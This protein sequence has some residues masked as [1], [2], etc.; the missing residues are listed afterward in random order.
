MNS[1]NALVK[2]KSTGHFRLDG[3]LCLNTSTTA[4]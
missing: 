2:R 1:L 3:Q 4:L